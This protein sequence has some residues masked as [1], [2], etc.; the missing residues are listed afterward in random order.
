[1]DRQLLAEEC[2]KVEKAGGDVLA[3]LKGRGCVSPW[4]TWFRLQKEELGRKLIDIT[5][6][7]E[8][9][10]L[11]KYTDEQKLRTAQIAVEG[12]N[13][14][15]YLHEIG[16]ENPDIAWVNVKKWVK[17]HDPELYAKIPQ[18]IRNKNIVISPKKKAEIPEKPA[19]VPEIPEAN[20]ALKIEIPEKKPK[21]EV[22][23]EQDGQYYTALYDLHLGEFHWVQK[24]GF[25]DW[26]TADGDIIS[27]RA[28]SW[29]YL[30]ETLPKIM[31]R[32]GVNP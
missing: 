14:K 24:V 10:R 27:M 22:P 2:L 20:A 8:K 32:L 29:Q 30:L 19:E 3:F 12:G 6:G 16:S 4:G 15:E 18:R 13:P 17:D 23:E 25:L 5:D 26:E 21:A 28:E 31:K 9:I 1:M 7:K 11:I